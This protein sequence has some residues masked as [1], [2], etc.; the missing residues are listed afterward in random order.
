MSGPNN[1][2]VM[3]QE[4]RGSGLG[5]QPLV[6]GFHTSG[7]RS[8]TNTP[9][10]SSDHHTA[11]KYIQVLM[12]PG[13]TRSLA[14]GLVKKKGSATNV[15]AVAAVQRCGATL[16]PGSSLTGEDG[17]PAPTPAACSDILSYN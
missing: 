2:E 12:S 4:P 13:A 7:S 1:L 10:V 15:N 11:T 16:R 5:L 17:M 3:T 14:L 6:G 8:L 9:P